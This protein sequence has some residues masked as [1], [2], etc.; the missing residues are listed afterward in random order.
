MTMRYT[1]TQR[2]MQDAFDSRRLADRVGAIAVSTIPHGIRDFIEARDMFFL[3]TVRSDGWPDTSYKGG[4]PGFV[5]VINETTLEFPLYDGNG[6]FLSAGN[7]VGDD[8][9][10]MLFVDFEAGSRLRI[11]G[12]A[13]VEHPSET[14]ETYPGALMTVRVA[15]EAVFPN[16]RR[17]V[18]RYELVERSVFVPTSE[19][20]GPV[21]DWKRQEHFDGA[22]PE[23]DPA[24]DPD[25][26]SAPSMPF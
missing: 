26:P 20:L 19:S 5:R 12:R 16:C 1:E 22:L 21:P 3:A 8:R 14:G 13:T 6:M 15:V 24:L 25:A 23:G 11:H 10:S 9:I 2:E 18:H 4:E 7:I 17:Y